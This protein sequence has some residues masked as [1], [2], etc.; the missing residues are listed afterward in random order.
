MRRS[1]E[2]WRRS[3]NSRMAAARFERA[4]QRRA[5]SASRTSALPRIRR[6]EASQ[7]GRRNHH[8]LDVF[9]PPGAVDGPPTPSP[10]LL[11]PTR[12]GARIGLL[13]TEFKVLHELVLRLRRERAEGCRRLRRR[14]S[15]A[16]RSA[17]IA[18]TCGPA[19]RSLACNYNSCSGTI[20]RKCRSTISSV[21]RTGLS[22]RSSV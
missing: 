20:E 3:G 2:V 19:G 22:A 13:R 7:G 9:A 12:R 14:T 10:S 11:A 17:H 6:N 18:R 4:I 8:R 15:W 5:R 1:R 21:S 16:L